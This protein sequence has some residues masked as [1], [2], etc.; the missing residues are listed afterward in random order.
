MCLFKCPT[1]SPPLW[2]PMAPAPQSPHACAQG[3]GRHAPCGRPSPCA[4]PCPANSPRSRPTLVQSPRARAPDLWL[5]HAVA[6]PWRGRP[7]GRPAWRVCPARSPCD[8]AVALATTR[9]RAR[10][11]VMRAAVPRGHGAKNFPRAVLGFFW[12]V[13]FGW[14]SSPV[15][16]SASVRIGRPSCPSVRYDNPDY[17]P[18]EP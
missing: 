3:G 9:A 5:P 2:P 10:R 6:L 16:P 17:D 18:A 15:H 4:R 12:D 1:T 11:H 7:R 8:P 13:R 14:M